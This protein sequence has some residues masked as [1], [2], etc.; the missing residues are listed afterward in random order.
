MTG[1]IPP[2]GEQLEFAR[3]NKTGRVH[4]LCYGPDRH[5][6]PPTRADAGPA[7]EVLSMLT[8]PCRML[9]APGCLSA[10]STSTRPCGWPVTASPTM[11]CASRAS[12]RSAI[13]HGARSTPTTGGHLDYSPP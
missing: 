1:R 9:A 12:R 13:S 11:I 4:I 10:R 8:A 2:L 6:I 7:A 3:N 5:W